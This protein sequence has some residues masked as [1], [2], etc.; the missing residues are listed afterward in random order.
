MAT[1]D[2]LLQMALASLQRSRGSRKTATERL[3]R[4][5]GPIGAGIGML[6][7]FYAGLKQKDAI[8][9]QDVLGAYDNIFKQPSYQPTLSAFRVSPFVSKDS[10]VDSARRMMIGSA[11]GRA[12]PAVSDMHSD[13][14]NTYRVDTY[15][16]VVFRS[17]GR[18]GFD[19]KRERILTPSERRRRIIED[20][21]RKD[22]ASDRSKTPPNEKSFVENDSFESSNVY[23][24][25]YDE[26][27]S[28]LY[29]TFRDPAFVGETDIQGNNLCKNDKPY[30]YD[31]HARNPGKTFAYTV[32]RSIYTGMMS[33]KSKGKF[34]WQYLR[35]CGTVY[36]HQYPV[37][38]VGP[39]DARSMVDKEGR[40]RDR[41][42]QPSGFR[43]PI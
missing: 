6:A 26:G 13:V 4:D 23:S 21:V 19:Q 43:T 15:P 12:I 33:A 9:R 10:G 2:D 40:Q 8:R 7:D 18:E 1:Q 16:D 30:V 37:R 35:E 5:L 22:R 28:E 20:E 36:G 14:Y 11:S 3:A 42:Y 34:V 32:P 39:S 24:F 38:E 25:W 17:R 27:A 41:E 31:G 29:I